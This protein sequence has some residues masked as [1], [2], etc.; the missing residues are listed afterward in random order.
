MPIHRT[1]DTEGRRLWVFGPHGWPDPQAETTHDQE[2]AC[3][4]N[5]RGQRILNATRNRQRHR[6]GSRARVSCYR[7]SGTA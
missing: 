4:K 1:R 7:Q 6:L 5:Q 2:G 3:R